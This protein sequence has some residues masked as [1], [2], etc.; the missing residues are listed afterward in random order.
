M[1]F[2]FTHTAIIAD[3]DFQ[4]N[5]SA[6]GTQSITDLLHSFQVFAAVTQKDM[7]LVIA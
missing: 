6:F 2:A 4:K 7:V 1:P 3:T 5:R